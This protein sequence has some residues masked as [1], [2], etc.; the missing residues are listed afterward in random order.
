M[1]RSDE[2]RNKG[3]RGGFG[4]LSEKNAAEMKKRAE[5][6]ANRKK[7]EVKENA[8]R[9]GVGTIDKKPKTKTPTANTVAALRDSTTSKNRN[10]RGVSRDNEPD[11]IRIGREKR[12]AAGAERKQKRKVETDRYNAVQQTVKDKIKAGGTNLTAAEKQSQ[13][14]RDANK[15]KTPL[16]K[17]FSKISNYGKSQAEARQRTYDEAVAKK[18]ASGKMSGVGTIDMKKGGLVKKKSIDGIAMRGKTRAA[19]SK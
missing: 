6:R 15:T 1:A 12:E 16:S 18:R 4:S 8:S 13:A 3:R 2:L 14:Y 17:F 11:S 5:E 7:P 19:R 10:P 9:V